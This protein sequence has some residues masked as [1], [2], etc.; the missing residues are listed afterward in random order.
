MGANIQ[1]IKASERG[2]KNGI[3]GGSNAKLHMLIGYA[4]VLASEIFTIIIRNIS[5]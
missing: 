2:P 4:L 3:L 1:A 5:K